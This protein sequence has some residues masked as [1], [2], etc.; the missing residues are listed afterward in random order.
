MEKLVSVELIKDNPYQGRTVYQ[1]IELLGRSIAADGIQEKPK[2]RWCEDGYELKFGHRRLRAFCWLKDNYKSLE[3][4]DRYEGYTLMPLDIEELNDEEMNRGVIIEN[5]QR[6]DL[7]AIEE[8][9]MMRDYGTRWGKNSEQVGEVFGKSGATVRGMVRLLD[10]HP[11]AQSLLSSGTISQGVARIFL[12]AQKILNEKTLKDL[13]TKIAETSA[14]DHEE[15]IETAIERSGST[16]EMWGRWDSERGGKPRAG[17]DLWLLDM[18]NFPNKLLAP[19]SHADLNALGVQ[20]GSSHMTLATR[21]LKGEDA[22]VPPELKAKI[23]HLANPPACNAC[24]FYAVV[25]KAHYCGVKFCRQRKVAAFMAQKLADMSRTL[26]IAVYQESDGAYLLLDEDVASHKK[27]FIARHADLR[28]VP[29]SAIKGYAYQRFEGADSSTAKIVAVGESAN[30]LDVNSRMKTKGGKKT[31][32]EK[33]EMRAMRLYRARRL[34]L[35]WEYTAA[36]QVIFEGVPLK[37]LQKVRGWHYVGIDDAIPEECKHSDTGTDDRQLAFARRALV[38][39]MIVEQS[40]R[41]T[42]SKLV[43]ALGDFAAVTG[44]NAS[45]LLTARAQEWDAEIDE[46]AKPVAAETPSVKKGK[47][48]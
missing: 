29:S 47:K 19:L 39:G 21:Y 15:I 33:A 38:W 8:A 17:S 24:P 40:S 28:L 37:V 18:K 31:E 36:A 12:S 5:A 48:S 46:L 10:L 32:R 11:D 16:V 13:F 20:D 43:K 22:Y 41:Y 44:V 34:E 26:K 42:R 45:Q 14:N 35:T 7:N 30:K 9:K 2:A 23:D 25:N 3:L 1:D 4:I 6:A 27:A